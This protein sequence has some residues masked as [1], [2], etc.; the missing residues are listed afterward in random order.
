MWGSF[1]VTMLIMLAIDLFVTDG[2]REH[3][4]AMHEAAALSAASV[5]AAFAG[6]SRFSPVLVANGSLHPG[7]DAVSAC[8][9][10]ACSPPRVQ[11]T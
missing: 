6:D 11:T 8:H 7:P 2:R 1:T 10:G 5:G 3:R 9:A 4:I